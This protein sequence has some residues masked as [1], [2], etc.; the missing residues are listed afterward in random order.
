MGSQNSLFCLNIGN[1][2]KE[3]YYL[4]TNRDQKTSVLIAIL[5]HINDRPALKF[6]I[7][8]LTHHTEEPQLWKKLMNCMKNGTAQKLVCAI[9]IVRLAKKLDWHCETF[10]LEFY[11]DLLEQGEKIIDMFKENQLADEEKVKFMVSKKL[12][13]YFLIF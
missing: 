4:S 12:I 3:Q 13:H 10:V 5:D 8:I 11:N 9:N 2:H 6:C 7:D 1:F